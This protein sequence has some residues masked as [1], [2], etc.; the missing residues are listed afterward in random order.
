[1]FLLVLAQLIAMQGNVHLL[2]VMC[3]FNKMKEGGIG[4]KN[5][6]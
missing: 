2:T 4:V 3:N 6:I 1:V 5:I